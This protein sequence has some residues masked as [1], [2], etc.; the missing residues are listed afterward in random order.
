MR[1]PGTEAIACVAYR[2]SLRVV[3]YFSPFS[4]VVVKDCSFG[5]LRTICL[6]TLLN[7]FLK[8]VHFN[9]TYH[10]SVGHYFNQFLKRFNHTS[11]TRGQHLSPSVS[12]REKRSCYKIT[13][14]VSAIW[15]RRYSFSTSFPGSLFSA[16]IVVENGGREERPW[17]RG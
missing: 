11:G 6:S 1:F 15:S 3:H 7:G 9:K 13:T 12:K 4:D 8:V 14:D 2:G 10:N 16:S 17:E 5:H